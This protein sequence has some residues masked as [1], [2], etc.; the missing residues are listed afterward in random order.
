MTLKKT[1]GLGPGEEASL[2]AVCQALLELRARRLLPRFRL[3][4]FLPSES[5]RHRDRAHANR[6][7]RDERARLPRPRPSTDKAV[8]R[9]FAPSSAAVAVCRH[10]SFLPI[11]ASTGSLHETSVPPG[12]HC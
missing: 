2:A 3:P 4:Q 1:D 5:A 12:R 7:R 11:I 8:S 6:V 9:H 10:R